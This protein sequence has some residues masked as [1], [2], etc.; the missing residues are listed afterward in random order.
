MTEDEKIAVCRSGLNQIYE[1]LRTSPPR[2]R[3]YIELGRSITALLDST[4]FMTRCSAAIEQIRIIDALQQLAYVDADNGAV[5]DIAAWCSRQW[6]SVLDRDPTNV[7]AL[8]GIGQSWQLRAQACLARLHRQDGSSSSGGS[9]QQSALSLSPETRDRLSVSSRE[10]AEA[11]AGTQDYV[12]AR[13]FLQPATEY[14]DRAIDAA[15]AQDALSGELLALV[16]IERRLLST[17]ADDR[18]D[19]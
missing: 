18:I 11:R 14:L 12:E 3:N 6:Q 7:A 17:K 19:R 16:R 10:E 4:T 15:M 1:V 9:S 13:H 5:A 8:R 2:L